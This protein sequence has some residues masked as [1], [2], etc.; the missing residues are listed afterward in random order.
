MEGEGMRTGVGV[1]SSS[2]KD[3]IEA[4][5]ENKKAS[6]MA[7]SSSIASGRSEICGGAGT[8]DIKGGGT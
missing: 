8:K 5:D 7:G 3:P 1:I 2:E 4:L 6:D